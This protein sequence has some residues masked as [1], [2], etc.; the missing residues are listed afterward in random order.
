MF[1]VR[2]KSFL[3]PLRLL[4]Y[5]RIYLQQCNIMREARFRPSPYARPHNEA[6]RLS[7]KTHA[8]RRQPLPRLRRDGPSARRRHRAGEWSSEKA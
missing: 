3:S 1:T 7:N 6:P 4:L 8:D 5:S 2:Q